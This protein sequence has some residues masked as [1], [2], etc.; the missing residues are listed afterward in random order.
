MTNNN[1]ELVAYVNE[2]HKRFFSRV[3]DDSYSK[4]PL[5]GF[6]RSVIETYDISDLKRAKN[7]SRPALKAHKTMMTKLGYTVIPLIVVK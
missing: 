6:T 7:W 1:C 2:A 3:E 4:R 5:P